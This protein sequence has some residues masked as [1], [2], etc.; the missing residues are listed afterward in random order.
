MRLLET[1]DDEASHD[2]DPVEVIRNNRAISGRVCPTQDSV[3]DT[4]AILDRIG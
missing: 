2:T 3:E 1:H 4:P